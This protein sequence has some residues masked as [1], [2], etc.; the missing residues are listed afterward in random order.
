[1]VNDDV[2]LGELL[3]G[4]GEEDDEE[5]PSVADLIALG[6]EHG[7]DL[8]GIAEGGR[9]RSAVQAA[10]V[11]LDTSGIEDEFDALIKLLKATQLQRVSVG[12][13]ARNAGLLAAIAEEETAPW[14]VA[15]FPE[16]PTDT[17]ET[18]TELRETQSIE[19]GTFQ[20]ATA[21]FRNTQD[22][23]D[24]RINID[25]NR[26]VPAEGADGDWQTHHQATPVYDIGYEARDRVDVTVIWR[27][28]DDTN[29]HIVPV[30][31]EY[32]EEAQG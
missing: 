26:V 8:S 22:L 5:E 29:V 7:V 27:N 10:S 18:T 4:A 15:T 24:L 12:Q 3:A 2:D 11:D 30:L 14:R 9:E 16:D 31:L 19:A 13:I 1:M 25:G 32:T 6:E 17:V 21:D 23:V 20:Q 28:R